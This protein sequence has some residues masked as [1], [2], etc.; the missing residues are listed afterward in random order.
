MDIKIISRRVKLLNKV[1]SDVVIKHGKMNI[2]LVMNN[3]QA[4]HDLRESLYHNSLFVE[5]TEE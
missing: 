5:V 2:H 4:A 1:A 3:F